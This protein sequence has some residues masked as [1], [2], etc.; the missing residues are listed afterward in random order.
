MPSPSSA[1]EDDAG[2]VLEVD[3]VHDAGAGRHDPEVPKR[4]LA[5]AQ[6]PVALAVALELELGVALERVRP[7]EDVGDLTEWSMTSSTGWSGLILR[8]VAAE[9]PHRVAHR[10]QVDDGR[11]AGEVL[12]EHPAGLNC[13]L[14]VRLGARVPPGQRLDVVGGDVRAVLGAQQV[15]QQDLQAER[16]VGRPGHRV[17]AVDL[18]AGP[19]GPPTVSVPR[20]SKLFAVIVLPSCCPARAPSR[21]G[22][23]S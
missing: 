23:A 15:L 4:L 12:Q 3:L 20:A 7:A 14:R 9:R 21:R 13:D 19:P 16:Q 18:V 8:G 22:T 1:V 6:E 5:P 17:K 11:H 2:Q 10:G